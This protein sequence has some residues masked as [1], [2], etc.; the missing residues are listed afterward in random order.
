MNRNAFLRIKQRYDD[1]KLQTKI[2]LVLVVAVTVPM[3]MLGLFFYGRLYDMVVSYTI[4]EEQDASARTAPLIDDT[5]QE[6]LDGYAELSAQPFYRTLFSESLENAA[7]V[8]SHPDDIEAFRKQVRQTIDGS[9]I[10]AVRIYAEL[11]EDLSG[12]YD[13]AET[14]SFVADAASSDQHA[15]ADF[16]NT[17]ILPMSSARGT[18]WYGIFQGSHVKELFCP[19][20]YLGTRENASLGDL[21]YIRSLTL[22]CGGETYPCY[23]AVYC[24]SDTLTE[25]LSDNLSLDGSVSYIMNDRN[26]LVASSD[27]SLSGIY[28]LDYRTIHD[29]FMS[30]NSF[31]ERTILGQKIYVGFY[32]I[33]QPGWFM[34]TI[35]PSDPLTRQSNLLMLQY[36]FF[37]AGAL[38]LAFLLANM[39][40]RS[41][42]RRISSVISQMS[43]VREGP[44]VPLDEPVC[45][46]EIGDLIETYN[47]MTREMA[48]LMEEQ[49]KAAEDLRI[50]EFNSL[51]AQMNPHFLYN[52][53]DM[54]NWLAKQGRNDEVC[55]AVQNLSRFYKLTLSRKKSISTIAQE[56]EHV[57]IYVQLQNMRYHDS[58]EFIPDIPDELMEYQIPKLTLQPVV[59]NA[60]L[61]GILEKDSKSGTIVLTGW[62]EDGDIVLLISDDGV[63][64]PPEKLRGILVGADGDRAAAGMSSDEPGTAENRYD[65]TSDRHAP[66]TDR[67]GD[68]TDRQIPAADEPGG[69]VNGQPQAA[70]RAAATRTPGGTNIG[71]YNTHRRL[72]ILYGTEY[73]LSY[74]SELGRGTDVQIRFPAQK[75]YENPYLL[76]GRTRTGHPFLPLVTVSDRKD[77]PIPGAVTTETLLEYSQKLTQNLYSIRNLHQI[78]SQLPPGEN[79]YILTHELTEDFPDHTHNHFELNYICRGSCFNIIDGSEICMNTGDLVFLNRRAVHALQSRQKETLIVNLCLEPQFFERTLHAFCQEHNPIA[80]FFAERSNPEDGKSR[81]TAASSKETSGTDGK[82]YIFFS[83][84]HSLHAQSLITS[85]IQEYADA[86]FHQT[87]AVEAMLLL[88]FTYLVNSDEFSYYGIDSRTHTMIEILRENCMT[89]SLRQIASSFGMTEDQ[90]NSHLKKYTGRDCQS[91]IGEV[92]L[93]HASRLLANPN[94]NIYQIAQECGYKNAEEF[95]EIFRRKFHISPSEYRKQFL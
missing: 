4:R 48:R 41:I 20:F 54:I 67:P 13:I 25:I 33:S 94:L 18:Y 43:L 70:G 58:I 56:T 45:H 31:I 64:I 93:E 85:V 32:S 28:W 57:S 52:T 55:S 53:M 10:T 86:G 6:I 27:D 59:E 50:A 44:P 46:D 79:L 73:G 84:G 36:I 3:L 15:P 80:D 71:I 35:L 37:Y 16:A 87:F 49:G 69:T 95:F 1:L 83:L 92:R 91:Y 62:M 66:A 78:S 21:A 8:L 17:L 38:L 34:V 5:V 24:S 9:L 88:L 47:Y 75:K 65:G 23:M 77:I 14:A 2:A 7:S 12:L 81:L 30:S 82:N 26:S 19:S 74:T 63:G 22:R 61:H 40:A 90:L 29:S 42:T 72:Q 76:G 89:Q 39:L 51:Q 11:P 60:V 68:A